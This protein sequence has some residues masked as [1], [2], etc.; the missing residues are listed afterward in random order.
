MDVFFYPFHKNFYVISN[1]AG[2]NTRIQSLLSLFGLN[3]RLIT[4]N[5]IPQQ[6]STIN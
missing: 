3:N 6:T 2:G 4:N 1:S 5:Y